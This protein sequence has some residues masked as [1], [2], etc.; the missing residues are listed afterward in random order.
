MATQGSL[1]AAAAERIRE[2]PPV[3]PVSAHRSSKSLRR[4]FS[5]VGGGVVGCGVGG[6]SRRS[7]SIIADAPPTP[8]PAPDSVLAALSGINEISE[9]FSGGSGGGVASAAAAGAVK[10]PAASAR[11]GKRGL[12]GLVVGG[13]VAREASAKGG[14]EKPRNVAAAGPGK[15]LEGRVGGDSPDSRSL[16]VC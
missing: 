4:E 6:V 12:Q 9:E 5:V 1:A 15:G 8:S 16:Q 2:A 13:V 3:A 14:A 7:A 10:V 11:R